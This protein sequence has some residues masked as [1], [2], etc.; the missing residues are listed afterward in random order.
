VRGLCLGLLV[1]SMGRCSRAVAETPHPFICM[2]G[3]HDGQGVTDAFRRLVPRITVIEGTSRNAAFI[4]ELRRKKC[5]Y[6]AHVNNPPGASV[7][8]LLKRWGAPFEDD[9]GGKL[10]GGYDAIAI[11]E[12][13]QDLDGS[14]QSKIVCQALV[15]IRK[16]FP[17]KQIY[18][19]ATWQLGR[20][21]KRHTEQLRAVEKHVDVLM[22]EVY[23]R[24]SRPS[25]GYFPKWARELD[26]V[27]PKLLAKTVYGLGV[28][29]RGYLFDDS[30]T[31]SFLAHLDTQCFTIRN[32][33]RTATM[34]GVM[35]WV[36]YRSQ[37]E[38]TPEYLA[39]LSDH[40]FHKRRTVRFGDGVKHQL[41]SNPQLETAR[42][43]TL[44]S[45]GGEIALFKYQEVPGIKAFHDSNG[46]SQHGSGGL[47]M[48]RAARTNRATTVVQGLS[49]DRTH[50][51]SAWVHSNKPNQKAVLRVLGRD[52]RVLAKSETT[53]AG[54]GSQWDKWTR[55]L[56]TFRPDATSVRLELNDNSTAVGTTLY[57]DFIELES[58][59]PLK[60][61]SLG[62]GRGQTPP[63]EGPAPPRTA[64]RRGLT[65]FQPAP[66]VTRRRGQAPPVKRDRWSKPRCGRRLTPGSEFFL[67]SGLLRDK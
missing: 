66:V 22:L 20:N 9:L 64:R 24:E 41:V 50:V 1:V 65:P 4:K 37:A 19:A 52:D 47:K 46:W 6:A 23:L 56:V 15:G 36:F 2:Y 39:K 44:E 27:A 49:A 16:Q 18:A 33:S 63:T 34:P 43:W 30:S 40:Y 45:G 58:G 7:D 60:N 42:G 14:P 57:W 29:Q 17:D 11:D 32:D 59:W 62:M 13:R 8:E 5:V 31:S 51:V 3:H 54:V 12:L 35:F 67:M 21:A 28:A 48:T 53:R 26:A 55:L 10:P 38:V 25:Y 61:T